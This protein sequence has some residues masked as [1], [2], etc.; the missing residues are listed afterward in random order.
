MSKRA[1]LI[2]VWS[3]VVAAC[4]GAT[5][6]MDKPISRGPL[7]ADQS[8]QHQA[9]IA[10][11]DAAWEKRADRAQLETAIS[12]WSGAV[13]LKDDDHATYAKLSRASYLLADGWLA[14]EADR[15]R[16][17]ATH[18][19]GMA[20]AERGMAAISPD[21][22]QRRGTGM[23]PEDAAQV[24]GADAVPLMYWYATNLGKWAKAEGFSTTLK[25]KDA[26]FKIIQRVFE[27]DRDY[28]FG[29]PDRYFGAFYAVAPTFAGGDLKK[30]N[31]HFGESL[32]REKRYMATYVLIAEL[33]APKVQ[34]AS[35]FD[36]HLKTVMDA[37]LDILPGYEAETAVEKRKAE[38]LMKQR[39]ELF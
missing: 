31:E 27:L 15:G 17:L 1:S 11:G 10:E 16:F 13:A 12:K 26:I 3:L 35:M 25:H 2:I 22:A 7:A 14:F 29:A 38:L 9:L 39:N 24:L 36:A 19:Q 18:K 33:Y 34:D 32:K 20:H 28:F 6:G 8:A 37:P 23:K 5:E 4:G 21:F 30:S